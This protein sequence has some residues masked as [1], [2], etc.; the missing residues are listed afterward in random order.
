[1]SSLPLTKNLQN[2]IRGSYPHDLRRACDTM[3][4]VPVKNMVRRWCEVVCLELASKRSD[5]VRSISLSRIVETSSTG[6][7]SSSRRTPGATRSRA[8]RPSLR[9]GRCCRGCLG[10]SP[11]RRDAAGRRSPR[12]PGE[13]HDCHPRGAPPG[14]LPANGRRL[15]SP[16][17]SPG[18]RRQLA[19]PG[20][21]ELSAYVASFVW[22]ETPDMAPYQA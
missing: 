10:G 13:P 5:V 12:R 2:T 14:R 4:A 19:A 7:C 9:G 8:A 22:L 17:N 11:D 20:R 3:I 6:I 16:P 1:M 18:C 15:K 21:A